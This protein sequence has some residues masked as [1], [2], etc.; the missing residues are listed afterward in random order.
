VSGNSSLLI[1]KKKKKRFPWRAT[2]LVRGLFGR[3]VISIAQ[4][5]TLLAFVWRK[6]K[7]IWSL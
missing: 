5:G 4:N 1:H 7:N 3:A 2:D 6:E